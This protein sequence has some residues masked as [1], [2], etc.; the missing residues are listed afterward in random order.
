MQAGKWDTKIDVKSSSLFLLLK[1][2]MFQYSIISQLD[3]N[4]SKFT[5]CLYNVEVGSCG[6]GR[7]CL[8]ITNAKSLVKHF[9]FPFDLIFFFLLLPLVCK[10]AH[11]KKLF[12]YQLSAAKQLCSQTQKNLPLTQE[13]SLLCSCLH[14]FKFMF[15]YPDSGFSLTQWEILLF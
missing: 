11:R 2:K 4:E 6:H 13:K 1:D 7:I 8:S 9:F 10:H 5:S 3:W 14:L 15:R 12:K